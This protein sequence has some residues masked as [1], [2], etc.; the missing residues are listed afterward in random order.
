M[1]LKSCR[2]QVVPLKVIN[3]GRKISKLIPPVEPWFD[4]LL[5]LSRL[6]DLTLCRYTTVNH[7]MIN[8]TVER[9]HHETSSFHLPYGE[10]SITL[11]D[12]VCL[13]HLPTRGRFLDHER[14]DKEEA[15]KL[16]VYKLGVDPDAV[17]TEMDKTRGSH[18]RYSWLKKVFDDE[19]LLAQ[20]TH[21]LDPTTLP[22][23]LGLVIG[24]KLYGGPSACRCTQPAQREP[25]GKVVQSLY[26]PVEF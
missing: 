3:H 10:M 9:W 15:L 6:K 25:G 7:G 1:K 22:P 11:D 19:L 8:V 20:Q 13:L 12:V 23:Y 2:L 16:L 5:V 18:V 26:S 17:M 24:C 4:Q 21:G 14:C